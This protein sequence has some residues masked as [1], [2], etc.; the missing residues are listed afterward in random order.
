MLNLTKKTLLVI[1]PHPDDEMIGCG[2]LIIKTKSLG[3]K[4]Y[5]LYLTVGST[6]DFT[7]KGLSTTNERLEEIKKVTQFLKSD[8]WLIAFPGDKYHLQL[9]TLSQKKL[10][11]EIERGEKISLE[12]VRPHIIAFPL[13][14]DYNQDHR[15][16]AQSSFAACR[17]S[18]KSNK[19]VPDLILSYN[20]PMNTWVLG[21]SDKLNFFIHLTVKQ[22]STKMTALRLYKSQV[23]GKGH[24]RSEEI[25]KA[26]ASFDGARVG[27]RLAEGYYCHKLET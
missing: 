2:G 5:V 4:V 22:F 17:P 18:P 8:G 23:R 6:A 16:A 15:A 21:N 1:A 24:L 9:D 14:N 19:F 7:K 13:P 10:I 27:G 11:H 3:G 20:T 26:A 12:S 25:L